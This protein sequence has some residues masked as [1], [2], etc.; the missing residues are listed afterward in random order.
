MSYEL[1][2]DPMQSQLSAHPEMDQ[3]ILKIR[4]YVKC[5][6]LGIVTKRSGNV[7]LIRLRHN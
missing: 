4:I 5:V 7:L 2:D 1:L 3:S 6:L